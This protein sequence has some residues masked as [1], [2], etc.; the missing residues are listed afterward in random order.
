MMKGE[1]VKNH[2]IKYGYCMRQVPDMFKWVYYCSEKN[3]HIIT[4]PLTTNYFYSGGPKMNISVSNP[5]NNKRAFLEV[6]NG[7]RDY[8]EK[9]DNEVF[10]DAFESVFIRKEACTEEEYMCEKYFLMLNDENPILQHNALQFYAKN[11]QE[12]KNC[13]VEKYNYHQ[14]DYWNDELEKG[15]LSIAKGLSITIKD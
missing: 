7:W 1:L 14:E 10:R 6:A 11:Y 13:I 8:F 12:I 2:D 4:K 3:V 9:V 5:N 15:V